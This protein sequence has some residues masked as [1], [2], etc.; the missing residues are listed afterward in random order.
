MEAG[1]RF[2]RAVHQ[3]AA[4]NRR[5]GKEPAAQTAASPRS[6]SIPRVLSAN[7]S[8]PRCAASGWR[9]KTALKSLRRSAKF[10]R[11]RLLLI[12]ARMG[13]CSARLRSQRRTAA[14]RACAKICFDVCFLVIE[15]HENDVGL[16]QISYL[17][18]LNIIFY[19]WYMH[20]MTYYIE[21]NRNALR[22]LNMLK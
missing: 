11:M 3:F 9:G 1:W 5:H 6:I 12:G 20:I 18:I 21:L 8:S 19:I 4:L 2:S 16:F 17:N 13:R 10:S 22:F 15:F 7:G 14:K